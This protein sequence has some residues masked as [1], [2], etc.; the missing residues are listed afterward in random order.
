M[1]AF[2]IEIFDSGFNLIQHS[3]TNDVSYNI[4]Y[5][6]PVEN[7]IVVPFNSDI[8]N[9][10]YIHI[11]NN[12]HDYF[13]VISGVDT[14][15]C[16]DG[17]IQLRYKPFTTIFDAQIMFDTDLQGSAASL[18]DTLADI[19]TEYWISN[20]DS[21]QNVP[22]LSVSTISTTN[23]WGF[24]LKSDVENMHKCAIN[25]RNVLIS[26]SLSKYRVGLYATPDFENH[27][28]DIEI[29]VKSSDTFYIEAALPNVIVQNV[30]I[31]E[32]SYDVNKLIVYSQADMS[33]TITYYLHP[34]GTFNTTN[35]NRITPVI[36]RVE[37]VS[38]DNTTFAEAAADAASEAFSFDGYKNLIELTV[39]NDDTLVNPDKIDLGQLV[40][41]IS[42][43]VAY[44][45]IL[46]GYEI[47]KTTKLIFGSIRVDLTKILKGA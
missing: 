11:A 12:E 34:D 19:I 4:D 25:F 17:W 43:G 10:N 9:R 42:N 38:V 37:S 23:N 22:G 7:S 44:P 16:P 29:G 45:S 32:G 39:L 3:N 15:K 18:E 14:D 36:F 33:S 8:A 1:Q 40:S 21:V 24:N 47:G 41:I 27:T 30:V 5:L 2:N 31:N 28:I 46:T 35:N 6:S 26:R 13:G 20:S